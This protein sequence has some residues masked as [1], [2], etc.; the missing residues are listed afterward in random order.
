MDTLEDEVK[1][2]YV[3]GEEGTKETMIFVEGENDAEWVHQECQEQTEERVWQNTGWNGVDG[4]RHD[5][6][7]IKDKNGI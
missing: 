5:E 1:I 3:C 4:P 2:C 7:L 6:C